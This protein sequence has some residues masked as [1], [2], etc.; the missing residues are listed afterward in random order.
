MLNKD[1]GLSLLGHLNELRVRLIRSVL[2]IGLAAIPSYIYYEPIM[3]F[4]VKPFLGIPSL[5]GEKILFVSSVMEG[6]SIKFKYS[7]LFALVFTFPYHLFSFL[8]FLFPG[9]REKEKKIISISLTAGLFLGA[10]GFYLCYFVILPFSIKLMV[11][12]EFIP[13]Q[14][15]ILLDFNRNVGYI[16]DFLLYGTLLFQFPVL[17]EL[18][19]YFN[20]LKRRTLIKSTRYVIVLI[21]LIAA[22]VTP[23]D[24]VS[25]CSLGVPLVLLHFGTIAV[26]KIF[27]F[28]EG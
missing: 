26:A 7:F 3:G 8:Q 16:V 6:F 10:L 27:K 25:Q 21:F 19:M 18:L 1:T 9:L 12:D 23:P 24:V 20:F 17:V 14:V 5:H 22:I 2:I 11:G 4:L 28:G 13:A 15:G